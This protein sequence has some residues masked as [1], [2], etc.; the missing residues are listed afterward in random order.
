MR[1]T[2]LKHQLPSKWWIIP[3][4]IVY[5]ENGSI[6]D[7]MQKR[8]VTFFGHLY[9]LLN[10]RLTKQLLD[11]KLKNKTQHKQIQVVKSGMRDLNIK[12]E[13]IQR[14]EKKKVLTDKKS[15]YH[16]IKYNNPRWSQQKE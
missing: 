12:E 7:T 1:T 11:Y 9:R 10:S 15:N 5:K 14:Q 8:R 13:I 2:I 4:N 6:T 3:N 16:L